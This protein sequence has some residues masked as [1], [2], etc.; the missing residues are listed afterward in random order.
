MMNQQVLN[1]MREAVFLA[2]AKQRAGDS[3]TFD[4]A[5]AA[6]IDDEIARK[7]DPVAEAEAPARKATNGNGHTAP[8]RKKK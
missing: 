5:L 2:Q 1:T 7:P 6:V 3:P 4:A 8:R